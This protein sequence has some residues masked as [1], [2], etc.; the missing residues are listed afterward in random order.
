MLVYKLNLLV[1][2]C[3]YDTADFRRMRS[4]GVCDLSY[5]HLGLR[6]EALLFEFADSR[7]HVQARLYAVLAQGQLTEATARSAA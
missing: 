2:G 7:I 3:I 4:D 1:L 6:L 5:G